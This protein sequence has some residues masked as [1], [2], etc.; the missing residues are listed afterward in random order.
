MVAATRVVTAIVEG[1]KTAAAKAMEMV[2]VRA[3]GTA[4]A[5]ETM[6]AIP[7]ATAVAERGA[8]EVARM[9]RA[10]VVGRGEAAARGEEV[11]RGVAV[12]ETVPAEKL[13]EE[14][15]TQIPDRLIVEEEAPPSEL[16][17]IGRP[18]V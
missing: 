12:R 13:L 15:A 5:K 3:M 6:V 11:P 17:M 16:A 8:D 7:T 9:V 14:S 10:A 18:V 2:A 4:A 1:E